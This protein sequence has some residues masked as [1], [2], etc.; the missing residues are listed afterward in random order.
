M[1]TESVFLCVVVKNAPYNTDIENLKQFLIFN[2]ADP[3]HHARMYKNEHGLRLFFLYFY[4]INSAINTVIN[5][6]YITYC[7]RN[8]I[9]TMHKDSKDEVSNILWGTSFP[10]KYIRMKTNEGASSSSTN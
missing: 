10:P 2:G 9:L 6:N 4:S 3:I 1:S 7:G 5:F 8:L